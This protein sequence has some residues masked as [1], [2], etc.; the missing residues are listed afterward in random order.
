MEDIIIMGY[1]GHAKSVCDTIERIGMY[2]I[3]GYTDVNHKNSKYSYLGTDDVL[4]E[5]YQRGVKNVAMG[6]GYLGEGTIR[7][8]L[9]EYAKDLGYIF[10]VL[11]DPSAIVST[12][13][14]IDE[15]TY[16]GKNAIINIEASIG[17]MCI[18]N[19]GS[20]IEHECKIDDFSHV[21]VGAVI[22]G[23]TKIAK[24]TFIGAN[25]TIIQNIYVEDRVIVGAGAV[26]VRDCKSKSHI[27]GNPAV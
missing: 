20:I 14:S 10:P 3:V 27:K 5:Y 21:A 2:H 16:V 7:E 6:I 15:G 19:T 8:Q 18:I 13:C 9:Y 26:V 4:K 11:L 1:G 12:E 17:K 24:N 22:C 23:G 25:A